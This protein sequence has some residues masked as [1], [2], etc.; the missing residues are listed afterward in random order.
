ME[1]IKLDYSRKVLTITK[2]LNYFSVVHLLNYKFQN[3]NE[4]EY[5]YLENERGTFRAMIYIHSDYLIKYTLE[6][7]DYLEKNKYIL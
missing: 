6:I 1:D 7:L 4:L 5:W 3:F 2:K